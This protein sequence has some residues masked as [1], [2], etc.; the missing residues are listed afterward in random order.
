[1]KKKYSHKLAY[2]ALCL[3]FALALLSCEKIDFD[4]SSYSGSSADNYVEPWGHGL[5]TQERPLTPDEMLNGI[6]PQT[7]ATCWVMG[8]AVGSAYSSMS[9]SLFE[10]P[11]SYQNNI[12]LASDSLCE[13]ASLCVPVELSTTSTKTSFS[14]YYNPEN[15]RQFIVI[16]GTYGQY[17]SQTGIRQA[18]EGYWISGFDMS[19][20]VIPPEEWEEMDMTYIKGL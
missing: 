5:G 17:Y 13:D 10:V 8:Y 12:L 3:P 4:T 9:N 20:I 15:F 6:R 14:L 2:M 19:S 11:T 16:C 7:T 1:M 18:T